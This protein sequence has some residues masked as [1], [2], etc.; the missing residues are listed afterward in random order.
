M[1][2][3]SSRYPSARVVFNLVRSLLNDNVVAAAQVPIVSAQRSANVVTV[4]TQGPH[5]L[6][7]QATGI[8]DQ[9]IIS[10]VPVGALSFNGTFALTGVISST[11]FTYAQVGANETQL[12]GF[13]AGVGLGAVFTDPVLAA[14][15]NSAYRAV[16]RALS[17]AGM[18]NFVTDDQLFVITAIGAVDP[19]ANVPFTDASSPQLPVDLLEPVGIF[20]RLNGSSDDFTPLENLTSH[21]GLPSVPQGATLGFW[22]WR[23]DGIYFRGATNTQQIRLRYKRLLTDIVDGTSQIL[24]PDA[25]DCIAFMA[26]AE[27]A[28]ARGSP[29]AKKWSAA[30]EDGLEKLI[31]AAT[32]NQQ[33]SI[34]RRK[35]NSARTGGYWSG[36]GGGQRGS[37]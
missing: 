30:G 11:Q 10:S 16:R 27:A 18:P 20:E 25:Q 37:W 12:G 35:P 34:F 4:T 14:Y 8:I 7:F 32:R 33:N 1:P 29:L 23:T 36:M 21:G 13:S 9:A 3:G 26:A 28:L 31:G 19:S 6:V 17:M 22:E 15:V 5:G 24:I 2:V